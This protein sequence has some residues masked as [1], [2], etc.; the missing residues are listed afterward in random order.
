LTELQFLAVD[1]EQSVAAERH[2]FPDR[3]VAEDGGTGLRA[4][5]ADRVA[6]TTAYGG[7][8]DAHQDFARFQWRYRH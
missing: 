4:S 8:A 6:I 1:R 7:Q 5:S 3:L 2:D